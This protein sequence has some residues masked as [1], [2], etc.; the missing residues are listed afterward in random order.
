MEAFLRTHSVVKQVKRGELLLAAGNHSPHVFLV[1]KGCLRSYIID[2]KGKEHILQ[3]APEDW[4]ISDCNS[5]ENSDPAVLYIDA[6]ED[7]TVRVLSRQP[8]ISIEDLDQASLAEMTLKF[9]R[10]ISSLQQRIILLISATAEER[11]AAFNRI[12]PNLAN[13]IP[14][15]MIAS[16]LD[17][18]S[19]SLGRLRKAQV[20]EHS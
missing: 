14:Q 9:R 4:I 15:K 13:R 2:E 18:A 11:Y 1:E 10:H 8:E 7:S 5:I 3:F 16:Y 12:Y 20:K 6:I 17:I 19:E